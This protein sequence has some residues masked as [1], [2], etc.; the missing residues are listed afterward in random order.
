MLTLYTIAKIGHFAHSSKGN[1][2]YFFRFSLTTFAAKLQLF[3]GKAITH[4]K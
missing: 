1:A 2:Y 4:L 3:C